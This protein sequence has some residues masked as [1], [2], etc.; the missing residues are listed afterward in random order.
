VQKRYLYLILIFLIQTSALFAQQRY[1]QKFGK[2]RVQHEKFLWQYVSTYN[3]DIYF[4]YG[5]EDLARMTGEYAEKELARISAEIDYN[6][7]RKYKIFVYNS[8]NDIE[9]SNIG[10]ETGEFIGGQ[11]EF[12][13]PLIQVAFEGNINEYKQQISF[14]ISKTVLSF[15]MYGGSLKDVFRSSFFLALPEW[16]LNGAAAH[17]AYGWTPTMDNFIRKKIATKKLYSPATYK[18]ADAVLVGQ[19]VWNYIDEHYGHSTFRKMIGITRAYRKEKRCIEYGLNMSYSDFVKDWINFYKEDIKN[20]EESYEFANKDLAIKKRNKRNLHFYEAKLSSEGSYLAYTSNNKGR[21]KVI[22]K[23]L[24]TNKKKVVKRGGYKRFDQ[25]IGYNNPALA[26]NKDQE[27]SIVTY[28]KG[29]AHHKIYDFE[30]K[31]KTIRGLGDFT[32]TL[33]FSYSSDG[34]WVLISGDVRGK[35]DLWMWELRRNN[36]KQLTMDLYNDLDPVFVPGSRFE[37]AYSS[38]RPTTEGSQDSLLNIFL[39]D[40]KK[41]TSTP[42]TFEGNN[43]HPV[44]KSKTELYF[45]SDRS[46]IQNVYSYNLSTKETQQITNFFY[47]VTEFSLDKNDHFTYVLNEGGKTFLYLDT[48][49]YF[50][51]IPFTTKTSLGIKMETRNRMFMGHPVDSASLTENELEFNFDELVFAAEYEK[52]K[53]LEKEQK[54]FA[55]E[56]KVQVKG[57]Y[58][59]KKIF[60]MDQFTTSLLSDPLRGIGLLLDAQMSDLLQQNRFELG[61]FITSPSFKNSSMYVEYLMLKHR[62]DFRARYERI[63]YFGVNRETNVQQNYTLNKFAVGFS[64]PINNHMRIEVSP[65]VAHSRFMDVSD[66]STVVVIPTVENTYTG[67]KIEWVYDYTRYYGLN[68]KA[69]NLAKASFEKYNHTENKNKSFGELRIDVRR[70][71]PIHRSLL[72]AVRATYGQFVGSAPKRYMVGGMDNWILNS[73]DVSNPENKALDL[74]Y[75]VDN[76]DILFNQ[77]VTSMRGFKYNALAGQRHLLVN[78]ELRL[79]IAQYIYR[80]TIGSA[81]IRNIQLVTFSDIGSAWDGSNPFNTENSINTQEINEQ[82]FK[83]TVTNYRS[84]FIYSYGCGIR[85]LLIG[86]YMKFDVAWG[87]KNRVVLDPM[88]HFTLGHDF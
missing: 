80:G 13:K 72:L 88:L 23:D 40:V 56:T 48:L 32:Q 54:L 2:N 58:K 79:P 39:Y 36:L 9:Q 74:S 67:A 37:F 7:Y 57:P 25:M 34:D 76:S 69:G 28:K 81:F 11:T 21:Y 66:F 3:F 27:L 17:L 14:G 70:Y 4:H 43:T 62:I 65:F 50:T 68:M 16:Y 20:Y 52:V 59:Y 73:T 53:A 47:D 75:G 10:L 77:F 19:S 71:Q 22:V 41:N 78:L 87:V 38:S 30:K 31:K 35:T 61:L 15:M 1:Q 18:G 84:P 33:S 12:V 5:G 51:P 6:S 63:A 46:G 60:Y 85:S 44:F 8:V 64:Y 45:L 26:W 49:S 86:Y 55:D 82:P 83:A 42:L 29:K 24:K